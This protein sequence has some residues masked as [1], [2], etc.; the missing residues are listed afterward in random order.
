MADSNPVPKIWSTNVWSLSEN[1]EQ[2]TDLKKK[3][4]QQ[5]VCTWLFNTFGK[6]TAWSSLLRL[7]SDRSVW[8]VRGVFLVWTWGCSGGPVK[9]VSDKNRDKG[10]RQVS[11]MLNVLLLYSPFSWRG[12]SLSHAHQYYLISFK[13]KHTW[14]KRSRF[15]TLYSH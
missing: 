8:H 3:K 2:F 9:S 12:L 10:Q 14:Y 13:I 11:P 4:T 1:I 5:L 6:E 15:A 7:S